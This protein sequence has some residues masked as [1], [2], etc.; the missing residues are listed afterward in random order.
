MVTQ[1]AAGAA[2]IV[3]NTVRYTP[4]SG[5]SGQTTFT[6]TVSD[7]VDTATATVVATVT[8]AQ[9]VDSDSDGLTDDQESALGTDSAQI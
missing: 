6:Y 1:P 2:E 3:G 8:P 7:G 5:F 9:S 4:A